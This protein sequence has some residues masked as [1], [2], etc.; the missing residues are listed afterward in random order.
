MVNP[1]TQYLPRRPCDT[2]HT[3]RLVVGRT[4]RQTDTLVD[5]APSTAVPS[6]FTPQT[7]L[8]LLKQLQTIIPPPHVAR[9]LR[10]RCLCT[11]SLDTSMSD[12]VASILQTT[13]TD[14]FRTRC[15]LPRK[16]GGLGLTR[17]TMD[18]IATEKSQILSHLAFHDFLALHHPPEYQ[19][20]SN[21]FNRSGIHLGRQILK[22]LNK[23]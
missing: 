13:F 11:Y 20:I 7:A 14:D 18:G 3:Y 23:P 10:H 19:I 12:T 22:D 21:H 6:L 4:F 17:H 9:R 5:M 15:Y 2:W 16:F 1:R 8:H